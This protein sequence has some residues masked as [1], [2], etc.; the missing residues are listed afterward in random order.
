VEIEDFFAAGIEE[1]QPLAAILE[2][3]GELAGDDWCAAVA[4]DERGLVADNDDGSARGQHRQ[5]AGSER[6]LD[7]GA[8][9][10]TGQIQ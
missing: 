2:C 4:G 1:E 7:A 10:H 8:E 6:E 3:A 9:V 5:W